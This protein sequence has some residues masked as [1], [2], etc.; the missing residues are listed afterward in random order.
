MGTPN[1]NF[2]L[3]YNLPYAPGAPKNMYTKRRDFVSCSDGSHNL[4]NYLTRPGAADKNDINTIEAA[5]ALAEHT[6]ASEQDL[7]SYAKNRPGSTGAFD[8]NGDIS[9]ERAAEIRSELQ[10]TKSI[11]WSGV[12]SFEEEYGKKYCNDKAAAQ[13]L[14]T[15][16]LKSLFAKSHLKYENISW[17]AAL[18]E[19]TDNRHIHICFWEKE[20]T[21]T[22]KG[23]NEYHFAE[24]GKFRTEALDNFKFA[25][26]KHFEIESM[27]SYKTR[28]AFRADFRKNINTEKKKTPLLSILDDVS[29]SGSWQFARQT[30]E[31]QDK[32]LKFAMELIKAND[33]LK[34]QYDKYVSEL[35]QQQQKYFDICNTNKLTVDDKIKNFANNNINELHNRIGNDVLYCIQKF[36]EEYKKFQYDNSREIE[37]LLDSDLQ[38]IKQISQSKAAKTYSTIMNSQWDYSLTDTTG[39]LKG[40]NAHCLKL[41][42]LITCFSKTAEQAERLFKASPL[43]KPEIWNKNYQNEFAWV[44]DFTVEGQTY[45]EVLMNYCLK[46]RLPENLKWQQSKAKKSNDKIIITKA[47]IFTRNINKLLNN[48]LSLISGRLDNSFNQFR[49][50]LKEQERKRKKA[51]GTIYE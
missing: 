40:Y 51:E 23:S 30:P 1:V 31:T 14:I 42:S 22:K 21:F 27:D 43:Y 47:T 10:K 6:E 29:K 49:N 39:N 24:R 16:T 7:L 13:K 8:A 25:V 5:K 15:K 2:I 20:P 19:N 33:N 26:A 17:Y 50:A 38:L 18:H 37:K 11:I 9:P 12:L 45:G 36:G 46:N 28:D 35:V 41:M 32:I 44:K 4:Y 48:T 34:S 3:E